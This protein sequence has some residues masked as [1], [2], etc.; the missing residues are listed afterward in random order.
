VFSKGCEKI[1]DDRLGD[2][3]MRYACACDMK[4]TFMMKYYQFSILY[5][6]KYVHII[7]FFCACATR[8]MSVSS[9][10]HHVQGVGQ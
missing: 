6:N 4:F 8:G 1:F 5:V 7:M 3:H 10:A 9:N 2:V